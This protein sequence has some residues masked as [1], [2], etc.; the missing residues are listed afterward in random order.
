MTDL[1]ISDLHLS[2]ERPA[3]NRAF[4]T[5]LRSKARSAERL[6]ILG[7]L[8]EAWVGDDDPADLSR[9]L[10]RQLRELSLA[11]TRVYFLHGNRDFLIDKDFARETNVVLLDE[12][13]KV[14]TTEGVLLVCHG[15]TLCTDDIQ[16][17]K[18][19]RRVRNPLYRWFLTHLPLS[20]RQRIA[21]DWREK[22]RIAKA[23]KA[24][25]IMDV[26]RQTVNAVMHYFGASILLHGHTHRP[27]IYQE[28]AGRRIV[29]G[30]WD[31][32]GWY[33]EVSPEG[34]ILRSFDIGQAQ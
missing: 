29:L 6:Y 23:N 12:Y 17:Q 28:T 21:V 13:H 20:R 30:D 18:F 1:F 8:V 22:S 7:D 19:R 32:K 26:N 14:D 25:N 27:G 5:F 9:E 11:G 4:F 10:V 2:P 34:V 31:S 16:Y 24:D 3:I 15:D 33:A